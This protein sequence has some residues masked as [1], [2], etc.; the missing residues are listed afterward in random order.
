MKNGTGHCSELFGQ[1]GLA[2][3]VADGFP[4]AYHRRSRWEVVGSGQGISGESSPQGRKGDVE[5][6]DSYTSLSLGFG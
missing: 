2:F 4:S 5:W 6:H 1:K 3:P